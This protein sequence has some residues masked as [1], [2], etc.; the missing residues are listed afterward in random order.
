MNEAIG[1]SI[2][3][4]PATG[5]QSSGSTSV[6]GDR[7]GNER[8]E[9]LERTDL[10]KRSLLPDED[11]FSGQEKDGY[12]VFEPLAPD[13]SGITVIIPDLQV[14]FDYTEPNAGTV[15][16]AKV[17]DWELSGSPPEELDYSLI[18]LSEKAGDH[19]LNGGKRGFVNARLE[20]DFVK[21][22]AIF[23]LQHPNRQPL[24]VAAG[25]LADVNS[26]V[27]RIAYTTNTEPGSS[28][29]PCFQA[30]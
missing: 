1:I 19:G 17:T 21:D 23:I 9:W 28:G 30:R 8:Q 18:R 11:T 24:K 5:G 25:F 4:F 26:W 14:R 13:V 22:E 10:L 7:R 16:K 29:S 20:H 3:A 27:D 15:V 6:S 12:I 2:A